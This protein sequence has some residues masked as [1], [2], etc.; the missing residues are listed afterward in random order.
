MS[1]ITYGELC[2]GAAKSQHRAKS[3]QILGELAQLIAVLPMDANVGEHY[4]KI[5]GA[6]E[7]KGKV[8]GNN[9]LWIAAHALAIKVTLATNN[10][11]EFGRVPGLKVENW[12]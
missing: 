1:V 11:R 9:D 10:I 2:C 7:Q 4:G 8:I 12:V 6:L 3:L 5:R